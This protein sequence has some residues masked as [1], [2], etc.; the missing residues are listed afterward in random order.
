MT[1]RMP[2]LCR[3]CARNRNDGTC[4]AFP[5][6]IPAEIIV[7]GG[8]HT[9]PFPGDRGIRYQM[10]DSDKAESEFTDWFLAFGK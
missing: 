9:V 5:S 1:T 2:T 8:D 6:R 4:D 7:L 10:K 3:S